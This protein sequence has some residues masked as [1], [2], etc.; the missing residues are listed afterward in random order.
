MIENQQK[1]TLW[2]N[3][4]MRRSP[5]LLPETS[6][7]HYPD[8]AACYNLLGKLYNA[9]RHMKRA[10]D[11]YVEALK[12]NPFMWDAFEGLCDAG[13]TGD[14]CGTM[15]SVTDACRREYPHIKHFQGEPGV[16]RPA[17]ECA[18]D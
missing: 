5:D 17:C 12:L 6:Q 16:A 2:A 1:Q 8:A 14:T 15:I 9:D 3:T 7:R 18:K 11:C 10:V 4:E 13:T